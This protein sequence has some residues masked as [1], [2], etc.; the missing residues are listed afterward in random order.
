MI[1]VWMMSIHII[2]HSGLKDTYR[3]RD[4]RLCAAGQSRCRENR[5]KKS[6]V[7]KQR[8]T[9]VPN[10]SRRP[11]SVMSDVRR[12]IPRCQTAVSSPSERRR[13]TVSGGDGSG[14]GDLVFR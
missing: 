12:I 6:K 2:A 4:D 7:S 5:S 3:S 11:S 14:D 8:G 9:C 1:D 13:Q 10:L